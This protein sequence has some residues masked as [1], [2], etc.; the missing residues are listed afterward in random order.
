M[1]HQRLTDLSDA[2]I[3]CTFDPYQYSIADRILVK[4]PHVASVDQSSGSPNLGSRPTLRTTA[5]ES[6][7]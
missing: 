5:M 2:G 3:R 6:A 7:D 4:I 1:P